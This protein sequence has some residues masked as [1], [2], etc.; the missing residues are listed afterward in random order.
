LICFLTAW[1][2][3]VSFRIGRLPAARHRRNLYASAAAGPQRSGRN[4]QV[5]SGRR[6][7][8]L[9]R[10]HLNHVPARFPTRFREVPRGGGR[11]LVVVPACVPAVAA[12]KRALALLRLLVRLVRPDTTARLPTRR[13]TAAR[14]RRLLRLL[15]RVRLH[16]PPPATT[17]RIVQRPFCLRVRLQRP[18]PAT[19]CRILP[20]R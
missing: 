8:R 7:S 11:R 18:P 20:Q 17:T 9:L 12:Q 15:P 5:L 6:L 13:R 10:P 1:E 3:P 14:V 19:T 2:P 16:R 4:L